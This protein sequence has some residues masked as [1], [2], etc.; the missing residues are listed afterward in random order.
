MR[1]TRDSFVRFLIVGVANTAVSYVLYLGLLTLMSYPLAFTLTFVLCVLA[2]YAFNTRFVFGARWSWR[3]AAQFPAVYLGQYLVGLL[4]MWV[5][6][7]R[8]GMD[9]RLAPLLVIAV[10]VPLTYVMARAVI[11]AERNP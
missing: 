5:L 9:E 4:L 1:S 11:A 7:G 10:S 6:V 8:L 3:G 2:S